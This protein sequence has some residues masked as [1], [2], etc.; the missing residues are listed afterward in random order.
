MLNWY[1][2][3]WCGVFL[4]VNEGEYRGGDFI[5]ENRICLLFLSLV[6]DEIYKIFIKDNNKSSVLL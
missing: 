2:E 3:W 6:F 5:K 4:K 1:L